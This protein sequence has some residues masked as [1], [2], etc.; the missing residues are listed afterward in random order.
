M[1]P[2]VGRFGYAFHCTGAPIVTVVLIARDDFASTMATIGSLRENTK[3]DVELVVVDCGSADETRALADYVAGVRVLRLETA[4]G[5]VPAANGGS[6]F[7]TA[8]AILFLDCQ[9]QLAP[10]AIQRALDRH[11]SRAEP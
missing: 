6:Q 8:P 1:L 11:E 4:P 9:A 3:G 7:A 5:W 2:N 10:G